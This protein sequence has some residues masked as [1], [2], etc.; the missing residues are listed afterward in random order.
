META[1]PIGDA[2]FLMCSFKKIF[3]FFILKFA[4]FINLQYKSN[5]Y[6]SKILHYK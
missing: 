3:L 6:D 1:R 2:V 5:K 4:I